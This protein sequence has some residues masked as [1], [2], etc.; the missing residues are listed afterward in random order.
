MHFILVLF[1]SILTQ[2][3]SIVSLIMQTILFK[4][5]AQGLILM[6]F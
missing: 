3:Q 5:A 2:V 6:S 4:I 1:V